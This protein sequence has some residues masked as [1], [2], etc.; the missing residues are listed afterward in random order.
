MASTFFDVNRS[1]GWGLFGRRDDGRIPLEWEIA[2]FNG[3]VTGGAE[4]GSSG[5]LDNNFAFSGRVIA[6]PHGE[7]GSTELAD[8]ECHRSLA[9]RMSASFANSVIDRAG[10][11]EFNVLRVV[12]SGQELANVLPPG[13]DRYRAQFTAVS[14]SFKWRGCVRDFGVLFSYDGSVWGRECSQGCA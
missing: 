3:L 2:T 5:A 13:V 9:T 12:D 6:Y 14:S 8:L 7:W 4:T 10:R 11:T 1:L